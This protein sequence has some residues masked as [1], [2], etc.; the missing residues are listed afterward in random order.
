MD[1]D[2]SSV[3]SQDTEKATDIH[4]LP[5]KL[6]I[7]SKESSPAPVPASASSKL[8]SAA[9]AAAAKIDDTKSSSS[10]PVSNAENNVNL[11]N[12]PVKK[13][14]DNRELEIVAE[15]GVE[16]TE[17]SK[18]VHRKEKG[19]APRPPSMISSSTSTTSSD[20][21]ESERKKDEAPKAP[22]PKKDAAPPP[23]PP[24][25]IDTQKPS[26]PKMKERSVSNDDLLEQRLSKDLGRKEKPLSKS[27][28][29]PAAAEGDSRTNKE[30]SEISRS[31]SYEDRQRSSSEKESS[32]A[33]KALNTSTITINSD[34]SSSETTPP[35]SNSL[36][37]ANVNQ[38]TVITSHPP[39][40]VD[41]SIL[42][43]PPPGFGNDIVIVSTNND[44]SSN[45]DTDEDPD[46]TSRNSSPSKYIGGKIILPESTP[47]GRKLD[48]S[49]VLIVSPGFVDTELTIH[50]EGDEIPR[51][52]EEEP[53]NVPTKTGSRSSKLFDTSHV[54]VVTLGEEE[55]KVKDSS[56][57]P[58]ATSSPLQITEPIVD[59]TS[60][61]IGNGQLVS[62]DRREDV[63]IIVNNNK[64]NGKRN[65]PDSSVGSMDSRNQ[66]ECGSV[67]S[68]NTPP[69]IVAKLDRSDV[70]S[71]ATTT[72]HDS[73]EPE[74]EPVQLRRKPEPAAPAPLPDKSKVM[75]PNTKK[76]LDLANLRKKTRK[77]TRK[78]EIDG[79]QVTT[80][81][82]KVI[83][84]DEESNTLYEDH[85]LRKQ[86]LRELKLLQKQEKKQFLELKAK[87]STA[88]EQQE[89]KFEVERIALERT[90]DAD[91]EVLARQHRQTVEKYEQQ[92]EAELRNTSKKIRAEQERELKLVSRFFLLLK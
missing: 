88:K 53:D 12:E 50:E 81:T 83:Y 60:N 28:S 63:N 61:K 44:Q 54:S 66:S 7:G 11:V 45:K 52:N 76:E 35:S 92:Q 90:Y 25:A 14:R 4:V 16:V 20:K 39:V 57:A 37:S 74:E 26:T 17:K 22:S 59:K 78:F 71:I 42:P 56:N 68:T 62:S 65:S 1:D 15:N 49:E 6:P 8:P 29:I 5:S 40:I 72:S 47:K 91:M 64:K 19:P 10:T 33:N 79:V 34:H 30:K 77:R 13:R 24:P 3:Q 18:V 48:E 69:V 32:I 86:E 89:K 85:I 9:A 2:S 67:R 84:D 80:T 58:I 46:N 27:H 38:V 70:E 41:N 31:Y 75:S 23:P 36:A 73:R 51:L 43:E 82:S 55:V 87:E 21:S